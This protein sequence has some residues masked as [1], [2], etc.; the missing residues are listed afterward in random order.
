MISSFAGLEMSRRAL[1]AFRLGIQVAGHNVT[2][3]KT[4]GYSRQRVNLGTTA[5]FTM[6]G[7]TSPVMPG[8]IGT[9]VKA[10]EISMSSRPWSPAA[11]RTRRL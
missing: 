1:N 6:P 11:P 9:G 4:E 7:L 10:A 5:P 2:N 3:V 8:Q